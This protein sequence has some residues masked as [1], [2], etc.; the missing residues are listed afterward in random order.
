MPD[1]CAQPLWWLV[2]LVALAVLIG[3]ETGWGKA[4]AGAPRRRSRSPRSPWSASLLP[5][6]A[7]PGGAAGHP[8]MV[9]RTLFNP[10]RRPAPPA[11]QEAAAGRLQRGQFALT[12][13]LV[14]DGKSTAFLREVQGNKPRRVLAGDKINGMLVAEVR[15]DRVKLTLG[16]EIRRAD[17]QGRHQSAPDRRSRPVASV[18]GAPAAVPAGRAGAPAGAPVQ[19]AAGGSASRADADACRTAPGGARRGRWTQ[20]QAAAAQGADRPPPARQPRHPRRRS[21]A[22]IAPSGVL[23]PRWNGEPLARP[24]DEL[25]R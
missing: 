22:G 17:A 2:P 13:T 12:G 3:W 14:I 5:E 10:T 20:Q 1:I 4:F 6:Y 16:D 25:R 15:P 9:Q 19:G 18:A 8:E 11:P 21:P 24:R 7:I 23:D